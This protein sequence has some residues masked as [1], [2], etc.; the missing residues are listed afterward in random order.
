MPILRACPLDELPGGNELLQ[1]PLWGRFKAEF[2][3]E[4]L[5]LRWGERGLLLLR[6]PLLG[7]LAMVYGAQLLDE[8]SSE[9]KEQLVDLFQE[10]KKQLPPRTIFAR[11]DFPWDLAAGGSEL[12]DELRQ[13]LDFRKAAMDIQPP[14]TV[15]LPL[16]GDDEQLLKA[17]KSKTRYNVRLARKRGVVVNEE[18]LDFLPQWYRLYRQTADRDRIVIHGYAYYRRLLELAQEQRSGQASFRLL[19]AWHEGELLAGIF[20]AITG[21]RATYLYGASSNHKRNLM[22]SYAIQWEAMRLAREAG[23]RSY[24]LFGIP[25][26][27]DR[28]HPMHGLYRFK[29]GFGGRIVHRPGSWDLVLKVPAYRLYRLAE[30]LRYLYFKKIRKR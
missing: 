22:A 26:S 17:M 19:A 30:R 27:D 25:P 15:V 23:C 28:R 24:D 5:S 11:F 6:R 4:P 16:E 14:S 21:D 8:P 29:T 3:W 1:S 20:V 7:G 12:I 18:G 9:E 10:L 2:A 13:H